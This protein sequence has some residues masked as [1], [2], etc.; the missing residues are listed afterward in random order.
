MIHTIADLHTH[1]LASTHAYS[2]LGEMADSAREKGLAALAVTDHARVMPGSPGPWFFTSLHELPLLYRGVVLIAGMEANVLD[3]KGTL[4]INDDE[5]RKLD[6]VVASIHKLDLEGL[7]GATVEKCTELWMNIAHDPDVNVIGHSGSPEFRYDYE[8]VIPEFGRCHKL[9][10]IN[11]HSFDVRRANIPNCREIALCCKR[12]GVPIIVSSDAHFETSVHDHAAALHMLE[13]IDFPEALVVN[14][15]HK[16]LADYL[17]AHTKILQN[18]KN[19][20]EILRG[21]E[22]A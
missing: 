22:N 1:T 6:W 19:A 10:E 11:S 4:D 20:E 17:R 9:V 12:H 8:R 15:N 16:R 2:S 14:A 21:M 18:R 7:R 13:E 5:R 3:L